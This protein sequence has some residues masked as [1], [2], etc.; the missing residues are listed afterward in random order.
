MRK[1]TK[2]GGETQHR[3]RGRRGDTQREER[4]EE[5]KRGRKAIENHS[6]YRDGIRGDPRRMLQSVSIS[7][8]SGLRGAAAGEEGG[9]EGEGLGGGG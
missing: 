7:S 6:R 2:G 8:I 9:R 3:G 4:Q 1:K 5:K